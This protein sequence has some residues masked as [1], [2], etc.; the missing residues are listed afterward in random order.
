[1]TV[2]VLKPSFAGV[3]LS[4]DAEGLAAALE[5]L[6]V[7]VRFNLRAMRHEFREAGGEWR[8]SND[9]REA[10]LQ[11]DIAAKFTTGEKHAPLRFGCETWARSLN[12]LL[13]KR[14]ADPFVDWLES[15]PAWDRT[16]RLYGWLSTVFDAN[17]ECLLTAWAGQFLFLGAVTRAY[18]PGTKIDEMPVLIG[19]QGCGK[20]TALRLALPPE[21]P[22]WFADGLHLAADPKA[23]AEALQGRVIVEAAEMAGSTRAELESLKAFLSRTDDGSVRLA[24]R[25][26]PETMLRRCVVV[27]TTNDS[28]CLPNDPTGNRRFV[29]IHVAAKKPTQCAECGD[30]RLGDGECAVCGCSS[31]LA[32]EALRRYLDEHREQLWA[33]A[34]KLYRAGVEARLPDALSETQAMATEEA[35][36]RDDLLEDALARWLPNA[37][38]TFTLADAATGCGL[39]DPDRVTRLPMRDQ[40]RLGA[41]LRAE[42]FTRRREREGGQ[43]RTHW[44]R[45]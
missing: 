28:H 4:R 40:R 2:A 30:D 1:M 29:P 42:G 6:G 33:E 3:N 8:E 36:R 37:P 15:L 38:R 18:E 35:R 12:A 32:V 10:R 17:P 11:E 7:E 44:E 16:L 24:Y 9:R 13:E 19:P 41:A 27:G 5:A 14:E 21:R 45:A 22:E 39:A 31:P 25:R 26:N 34:V 23:R 20:S 43:R